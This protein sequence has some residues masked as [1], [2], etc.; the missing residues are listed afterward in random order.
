M[1]EIM[2]SKIN[3]MDDRQNNTNHIKLNTEVKRD[4]LTVRC[5]TQ[6]FEVFIITIS[7]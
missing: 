1:K 4:T 6:K 5:L 2:I 3:S 7:R